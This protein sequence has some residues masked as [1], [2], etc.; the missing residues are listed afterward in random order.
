MAD[1]GDLNS[2]M[3]RMNINKNNNASQNITNKLLCTYSY[4]K[5]H[6]Y[7]SVVVGDFPP[8]LV[9]NWKSVT[10]DRKQYDEMNKYSTP[11]V[12]IKSDQVAFAVPFMEDVHVV[13]NSLG[14][15]MSEFDI[16]TD[17]NNL[18]KLHG[19]VTKDDYSYEQV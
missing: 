5:D 18:R 8:R 17:R 4:L 2:K 15:S 7:H 9:P 14:R 6:T 1:I 16:V 11:N 10:F 12:A 3:E 19:Y 13:L